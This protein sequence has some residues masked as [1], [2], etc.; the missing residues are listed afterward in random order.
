MEV[1]GCIFCGRE[2]NH[3]AVKENGYTGRRC[4]ACGLIFLSPRPTAAEMMERYTHDRAAGAASSYTARQGIK[5]RHARRTLRIV[6]RYRRSG[7]MLEIGAG[8][9]FFLDEA[10]RGG[11]DAFGIEPNEVE[12]AFIRQT[13]AIPCES[14]PLNEASHGGRLFDV[15]YHCDVLSHLPD[16]IGTFQRIGERLRPDGVLVFETG[17]LADVNERYYPAIPSF[18]YPDHLFFFGER[19]IG[20]LLQRTG[21]DL[22]E[23][24]RYCSLAELCLTRPRRQAPGK[25][26]LTGAVSETPAGTV[27]KAPIP[28]PHAR[29]L[30][31]LRARLGDWR[32]RL[33]ARWPRAYRFAR[34]QAPMR[35]RAAWTNARDLLQYGAKYGVGRWLPHG[36]RPQTLIVVAR[37]TMPPTKSSDA[38][39]QEETR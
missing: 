9:G 22:V 17:N 20:K 13:F 4:A 5:R 12:A 37:K 32:L 1:I 18:H 24:R 10:R 6:R 19:S 34:E 38:R 11:F 31:R 28:F 30:P 14:T 2:S 21:F 3:V 7:A 29:R 35:L 39:T 26:T 16:P 36:D 33:K 23:M 27:A 25:M 8:A 15:V